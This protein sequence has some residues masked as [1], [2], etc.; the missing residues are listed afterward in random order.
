M[1]SAAGLRLAVG[2]VLAAGILAVPATVV[3]KVCDVKTYGAKGDGTTKDTAAIQKAI[4]DCTAGKGGGTVEVPAG[5]YVVA[6]ISLKSNLTL[7]LAKDATLMGSPDRNEYPKVVFARHPT[8]QP[9]VGSVNARNITING[10]GT[11]DGNGHI[12]WDYVRGAPDAGVL[13]TDHPRP[14][15]VVFD[16]SNHIKMEGVTVQNSG[17]WQIVPYYADHV[18]FRNI[19]ILAP[20]SPNTDAIDPFSSSNIVIDHVYSS[21]GD[22][23]IAIKSGEINSPGP[24]NPSKNIRITDCTFENGHGLSI[25][26]E[27]AGGVQNVHAERIHFKGTDQGIRIKAARDRGHDVS[28]ITYKDITMDDVKTAILVTEYYPRPAPEGEVPA[29]PVGRLTPQFHNIRIE[30][31]TATNSGSAGYIV[32]LPESPVF[33]MKLKNVHLDGKTGLAIAYAKVGFDDVTVK[34]DTGVAIKVAKTATVTGK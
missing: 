24:D 16:H 13:G 3:A 11:I 17:F 1:R 32:G 4:D 22:D 20:R 8:V 25:G 5:T 23:N 15:G 9:L 26:S 21:V 2:V 29:E 18:V 6:P 10:E 28:N 7:H 33:D 27:I 34:A 14:M 19:R 12:W 31:V 30:N